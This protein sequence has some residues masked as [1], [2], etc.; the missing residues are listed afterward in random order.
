VSE[1]VDATLIDLD[2]SLVDVTDA[3]EDATSSLANARP[4]VIVASI[5]EGVDVRVLPTLLTI[6]GTTDPTLVRD[7]VNPLLTVGIAVLMYDRYLETP[8]VTTGVAVGVTVNALG[9]S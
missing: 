9:Y 7:R 1:I 5:V 2:T 6:P 8:L 3:T 4:L